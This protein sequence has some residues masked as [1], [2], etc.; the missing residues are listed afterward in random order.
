MLAYWKQLYIVVSALIKGEPNQTGP[1]TK[2]ICK[3]ITCCLHLVVLS[4]FIPKI[5]FCFKFEWLM[6]QPCWFLFRNEEQ[7]KVGLVG[8]WYFSYLMF[9]VVVFL[10]PCVCFHWYRLLATIWQHSQLCNSNF[11]MP[12]FITQDEKQS[13]KLMCVHIYFIPINRPVMLQFTFFYF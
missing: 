9:V 5:H 7:R 8:I 2:T 11:Q 3:C 13:E 4:T 1:K 6:E 10:L 12:D